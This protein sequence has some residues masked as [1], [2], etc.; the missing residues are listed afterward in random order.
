MRRQGLD[1]DRT[2]TL[3]QGLRIKKTVLKTDDHAHEAAM[4]GSATLY[5]GVVP[6]VDLLAAAD[7]LLAQLSA[8]KSIFHANLTLWTSAESSFHLFATNRTEPCHYHPGTTLAQ[9]LQGQGAFRVPYL[10]MNSTI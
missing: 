3:V 4:P 7:K 2:F 10:P 6:A 5:G 9:T 8:S 1:G